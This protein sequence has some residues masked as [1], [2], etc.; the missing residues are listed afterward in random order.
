MPGGGAGMMIQSPAVQTQLRLQWMMP[1]SAV[2]Q[3]SGPM[4]PV[5]YITVMRY[6]SMVNDV[7]P[8]N[9][10]ATTPGTLRTKKN[11][12]QGETRDFYQ[13]VQITPIEYLK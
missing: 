9:N 10:T 8:T 6:T 12:N 13:L 1:H 7:L 11:L 5:M 3:R 4:F 2:T